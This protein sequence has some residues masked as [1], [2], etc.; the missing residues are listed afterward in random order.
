M[1]A[2]PSC[3][4]IYLVYTLCI[5]SSHQGCVCVCVCVFL[6]EFDMRSC[7]SYHVFQQLQQQHTTHDICVENDVQMS[8]DTCLDTQGYIYIYTRPR[9]Y[10]EL[11]TKCPRAIYKA[12]EYLEL[13]TNVRGLGRISWVVCVSISLWFF[14]PEAQCWGPRSDTQGISF[15]VD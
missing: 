14:V 13:C 9:I 4:S 5:E 10:L 6:M 7:R 2:P 11:C 3:E 8:S 1:S 12:Q 15:L